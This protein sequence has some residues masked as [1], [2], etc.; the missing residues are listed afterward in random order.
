MVLVATTKL[1]RQGQ[2]TLPVEIRR[3][4]GIEVGEK[5]Y[6]YEEPEGVLILPESFVGKKLSKEQLDQSRKIEAEL[7]EIN[8]RLEKQGVEFI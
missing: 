1:T 6:V 4:F 5:L 2:I 7:D 3:D 8:K